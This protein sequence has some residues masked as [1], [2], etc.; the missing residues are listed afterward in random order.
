MAEGLYNP[1]NPDIYAR[2]DAM[3]VSIPKPAT[4]APQSEKTGAAIGAATASY[5]LEDHQHPRLT[6]T[7]AA[8]LSSDG[9]AS[10][11]F[12]RTFTAQPGVVMTEVNAVGNQPLVMVVQSFVMQDG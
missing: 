1:L 4:A 3:G 9:T 2:L 10:A 8:V 12:T 5:A 11:M 7:T 6:S